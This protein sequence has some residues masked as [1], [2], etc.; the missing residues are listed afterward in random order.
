MKNRLKQNIK[1]F[2]WESNFEDMNL[3]Q[4]ADL[5]TKKWKIIKIFE[6]IYKNE[7]KNYEFASKKLF[8][9]KKWKITN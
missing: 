6:S 5:N 8:Q 7:Q 3:L 9:R 2:F 1:M 4:K